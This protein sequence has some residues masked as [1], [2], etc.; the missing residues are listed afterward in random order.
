LLFLNQIK[1]DPGVPV[2]YLGFGLL[3][4][5]VTMSYFSH[6]QVWAVNKDRQFLIGGRTNRAQV[7]FE[8]ELVEII[9]RLQNPRPNSEVAE[10]QLVAIKVDAT[11]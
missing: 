8:R 10:Q 7:T 6:S 2:V 1:A 11:S 5:G 3:M 9:D 4:A